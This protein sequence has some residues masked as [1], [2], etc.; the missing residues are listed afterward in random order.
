MNVFF[1]ELN[2]FNFDW[3][4]FWI[5]VVM[6]FVEFQLND[7]D[8]RE[9]NDQSSYWSYAPISQNWSIRYLFLYVIRYTN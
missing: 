7:R 6:S 5:F 8:V 2:V 1:S 9:W 4:Y 3:F